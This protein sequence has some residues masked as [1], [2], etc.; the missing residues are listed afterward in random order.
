[1]TEDFRIVSLLRDQGGQPLCDS[2]IALQLHVSLLEA[3]DTALALQKSSE[4]RREAGQ[5]ALCS[6]AVEVNAFVVE[7]P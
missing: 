5:C 1:M 2:C 3:R 4:I 6:R 7:S